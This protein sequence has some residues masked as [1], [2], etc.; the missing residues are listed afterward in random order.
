[1]TASDLPDSLVRPTRG[2]PS[3]I[4]LV[5]HALIT[6]HVEREHEWCREDDQEHPLDQC[7]HLDVAGAAAL[8]LARLNDDKPDAGPAEPDLS[9]PLTRAFAAEDKLALA[10]VHIE[11][12]RAERDRLTADLAAANARAD[13]AET[14]LAAAWTRE[15]AALGY[16]QEGAA[17]PPGSTESACGA[18]VDGRDTPTAQTG[19]GGVE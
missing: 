6:R 10:E 18:E 12:M 11:E 15:E 19:S 14:Q 16:G 2:Q 7:P 3:D 17:S 4:A 5:A 9:D 8:R 13:R 1:M